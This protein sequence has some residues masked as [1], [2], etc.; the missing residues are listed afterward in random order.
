MRG[1]I[2]SVDVT[3]GQLKSSLGQEYYNLSGI[4]ATAG[5]LIFSGTLDGAITAHDEDTLEELWRFE[6]GISMKAAPITYSVDGK[7][8]IAIIAGGNAPDANVF[9]DLA[10]MAPGAALYVFSL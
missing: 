1:L 4:L 10:M 3:T 2:V 8:Y 5:G 9:P 6:T 7:Q